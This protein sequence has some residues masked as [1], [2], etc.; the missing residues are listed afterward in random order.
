MEG[1][2]DASVDNVTKDVTNSLLDGV[3]NS[4]VKVLIGVSDF[5]SVN[6]RIVASGLISAV[7]FSSSSMEG[8]AFACIIEVVAHFVL[9]EIAL[10]GS[11]T[12]EI[13]GFGGAG[14]ECLEF[15]VGELSVD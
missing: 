14:L 2:R 12:F 7:V 3:S 6:A 4:V 9:V 11:L 8:F 10:S 1:G 15:L 5:F 13:F